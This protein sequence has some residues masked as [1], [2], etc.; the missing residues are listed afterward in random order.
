MRTNLSL[1]YRITNSLLFSTNNSIDYSQQTVNHFIPSYLNADYGPTGGLASSSNSEQRNKSL[2]TENL[3][4]YKRTFSEKHF[5]DILAGTTY[6]HDESEGNSGSGLGSPSNYIEYVRPGFPF[7]VNYFGSPV[8]LIK[9]ESS[10]QESNLV[11]YLA[12]VNYSYDRKYNFSASAR[13]D[14]SSKFGKA[15]PYATFPAV[16]ASWNFSEESFMKWIPRLDFAKL[17]ASWGVSGRQFE[18]PYLAYGTFNTG[19]LFNG[20]S[21]VSPSG[22]FNPNLSWEETAQTDF[23]LDANLFNY[24]LEI[25]FDYYHRYTDKLLYQVQLPGNTS[26]LG[27][28]WRN[29]A[30]LSNEGIELAIKTDLIRS[31][32]LNWKL[33]LNMA[34]NWNRFEKSFDNR[35][36]SFA[37]VLG[38]PVNGIYV[39]QTEGIITNPASV[40]SLYSS[41]GS[42]IY[43]NANGN[44]AATYT[45]G[46]LKIKDTNGDGKI[47]VLDQVY[48]GSPLAKIQGGFVN[49]ISWKNFDLSIVCAYSL[50]RSILNGGPTATL[51]VVSSNLNSPILADL[52][53]YTFWDPNNPN[54]PS[55]FPRLRLDG[56]FSYDEHLDRNL[57]SNVNYLKLKTMVLGYNLDKT[58][59]RKWGISGLR[60]YISG[61]NLA[62]WTNYIGTD[63]ET[64][65][66]RQ[67]I[68]RGFNYPL[69]RRI[70]AGATINF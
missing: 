1:Q 18:Q 28:Q 15:I 70:S 5:V 63:P 22:L 59:V 65:D 3:L 37:Y 64:V 69:A 12:R 13:R 58:L 9:F 23:G 44:Q 25:A 6:Q 11:S 66:P 27:S 42:L 48:V 21:T 14:G 52:S 8:Q 45:V 53:K 36:I 62:T 35:D 31:K 54:N 2:L 34:R 55:D 51:G 26:V 38:R 29:A 10:F 61:E 68:D 17:R 39:Y 33:T 49:D 47:D 30:A 50:G 46:D 57:Q 24:R 20:N 32:D 16:S 7:Y 67:G 19:P 41:Q 56:P 43:L 60:L 40:P 4:T